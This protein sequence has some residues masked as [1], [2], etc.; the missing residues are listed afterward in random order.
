MARDQRSGER[1]GLEHFEVVALKESGKCKV[2]RSIDFRAS[3]NIIGDFTCIDNWQ[4]VKKSIQDNS[5][6]HT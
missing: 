1:D 5:I 3:H 2:G 6:A 4:E